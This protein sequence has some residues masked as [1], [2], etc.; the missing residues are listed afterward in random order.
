MQDPFTMPMATVVESSHN[1]VEQDSREVTCTK[2][3][4]SIQEMLI[5]GCAIYTHAQCIGYLETDH[6]NWKQLLISTCGFSLAGILGLVIHH[7]K[8]QTNQI[9]QADYIY[10]Q[11]K[12]MDK[13]D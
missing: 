4:E 5:G 7:R 13:N 3:L 11:D 10:L 9:S 1:Q 6:C 2:Y 12:I 8:N